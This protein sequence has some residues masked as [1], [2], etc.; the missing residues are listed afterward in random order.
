MRKRTNVQYQIWSN[1]DVG[2]VESSVKV[3]IGEAYAVISDP[4]KVMCENL[5]FFKTQV[6][7]SA[8]VLNKTIRQLIM[9]G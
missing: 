7:L 1:S 4:D 8:E 3:M 9:G 2:G 6:Y 5:A